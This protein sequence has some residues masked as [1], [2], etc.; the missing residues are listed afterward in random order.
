MGSQ[1]ETQLSDFHMRTQLSDFHFHFPF[2]PGAG[3]DRAGLSIHACKGNIQSPEPW[4]IK[5]LLFSATRNVVLCYSIHKRKKRKL[6][7]I[8][9]NLPSC[10]FSFTFACCLYIIGFSTFHTYL[11]CVNFSLISVYFKSKRLC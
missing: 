1:R 6:I 8:S 2:S 11:L 10:T 3:I 5:F 9:Q 4:Q 7:H